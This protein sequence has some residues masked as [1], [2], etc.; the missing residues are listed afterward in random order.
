MRRKL[1]KPL[2]SSARRLPLQDAPQH[3]LQNPAVAVV[4]D[5]DR[6]VEAAHRFKRGFGAVLFGHVDRQALFGFYSV[7]NVNGKGLPPGQAE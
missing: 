7:R 5:F 4:V 2:D 3:R 1:S 6:R